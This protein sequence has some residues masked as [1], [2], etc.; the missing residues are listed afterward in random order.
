MSQFLPS[1]IVVRTFVTHLYRLQ[2]EEVVR[3]MLKDVS[4]ESLETTAFILIRYLG[5]TSKELNN[6]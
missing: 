5:E 6:A 1:E 4:R 3:K 2:G